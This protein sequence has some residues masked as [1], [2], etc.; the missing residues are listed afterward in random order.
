MCFSSFC[1]DWRRARVSGVVEDTRYSL[2]PMLI[3][4][5]S[6]NGAVIRVDAIAGED[7]RGVPALVMKALR[8]AR[9]RVP[10][11]LPDSTAVTALLKAHRRAGGLG[12]H[13][14]LTFEG[15]LFLVIVPHGDELPVSGILTPRSL[16]GPRGSYSE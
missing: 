4:A 1:G 12:V 13:G 3:G 8:Q 7:G 14:P 10:V 5:P 15:K 2:H 16:S 6:L 9:M 11:T